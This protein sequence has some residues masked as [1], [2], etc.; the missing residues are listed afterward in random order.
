[1]TTILLMMSNFFH[2]FAVALLIVAFVLKLLEMQRKRDAFIVIYLAYFVA[3]TEFLFFQTIPTFIYVACVVTMITAALSHR[4]VV[5][6]FTVGKAFGHF[7]IAMEM[8]PGENLEQIISREGLVG[9]EQLLPLVAEI[10]SGLRHTL[11]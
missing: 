9:E 5:R 8:I 10:I 6:V 7:Y 11:S 3:A 4:H 2:D 1:M